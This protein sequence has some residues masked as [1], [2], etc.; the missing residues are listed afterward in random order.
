VA[1]HLQTVIENS[2]S[3]E[4]MTE[5]LAGRVDALERNP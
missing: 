2:L 5:N 1:S 4:G 3:R